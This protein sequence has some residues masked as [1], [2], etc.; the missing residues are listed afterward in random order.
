MNKKVLRI[1]VLEL[2]HLYEE[3]EEPVPARKSA[4]TDAINIVTKKIRKVTGIT[5]DQ[6]IINNGNLILLGTEQ[7]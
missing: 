7:K 1:N 6:L 2:I 5:P 4:E 3:G